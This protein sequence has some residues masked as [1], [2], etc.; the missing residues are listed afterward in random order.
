MIFLGINYNTV[1]LHYN[2]L[3]FLLFTASTRPIL[4][5]P[6]FLPLFLF[7]HPPSL[8]LLLQSSFVYL[9]RPRIFFSLQLPS[10]YRTVRSSDSRNNN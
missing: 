6:F 7:S 1:F 8:F 2:A 10:E 3:V 4:V 5:L 9:L